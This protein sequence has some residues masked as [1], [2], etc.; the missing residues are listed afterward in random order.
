MSFWL[1]ETEQQLQAAAMNDF[2]V[3]SEDL[4]AIHGVCMRFIPMKYCMH[5]GCLSAVMP[6]GCLKCFRRS[7]EISISFQARR[8]CSMPPAYK[9]QYYEWIPYVILYCTV[10]AKL[11]ALLSLVGHVPVYHYPRLL[12][13]VRQTCVI[14]RSV[15]IADPVSVFAKRSVSVCGY[16]YYRWLWMCCCGWWARAIRITL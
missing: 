4:Y 3:T 2:M 7:T 14:A 13:Q 9:V 10:S 5:S 16:R 8:Y 6:L 15:V 12:A 1:V 11:F